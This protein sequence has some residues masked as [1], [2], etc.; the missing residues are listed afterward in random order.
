MQGLFL[1]F[2]WIFLRVTRA[3]V[4][5]GVLPPGFGASN[6]GNGAPETTAASM[7]RRRRTPAEL[8]L[9]KTH[10]QRNGGEREQHQHPIHVH[11]G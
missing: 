9:P 11:V 3:L 6:D 7:R 1:V 4:A 5:P 8:D 2:I 10:R